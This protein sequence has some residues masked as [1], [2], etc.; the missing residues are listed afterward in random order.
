M[1]ELNIPSRGISSNLKNSLCGAIDEANAVLKHVKL[2]DLFVD[3][4]VCG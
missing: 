4:S 1:Y 2:N 3:V